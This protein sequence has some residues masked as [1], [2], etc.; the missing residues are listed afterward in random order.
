MGI[1][2][3]GCSCCSVSRS[4]GALEQEQRG[5][6]QAS[7]SLRRDQIE[8]IRRIADEDRHG[9]LSRVVQ[10]AIDAFVKQRNE[11]EVAV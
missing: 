2:G 9:N 7:V 1:D 3:I 5:Y 4:E 6:V 10:D 11:K 8:D